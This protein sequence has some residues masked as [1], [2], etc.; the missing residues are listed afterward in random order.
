MDSLVEKDIIED[1]AAVPWMN[2]SMMT[3]ADIEQHQNV[4]KDDRDSDTITRSRNKSTQQHHS[5]KGGI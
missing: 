5:W 1:G 3:M 4:M 2:C